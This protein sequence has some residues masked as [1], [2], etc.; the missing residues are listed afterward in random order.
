MDTL[1]SKLKIRVF[2]FNNELVIE[3]LK[4]ILK[5]VDIIQSRIKP[6]KTADDFLKNDKNLLGGFIKYFKSKT[7][8]YN[9]KTI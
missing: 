6:I 7:T 1:K 2:M 9:P 5:S 8:N 4:Q 3:V